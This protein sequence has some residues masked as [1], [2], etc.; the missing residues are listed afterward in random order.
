M[1]GNKNNKEIIKNQKLRNNEYY[2][3]QEEFDRLYKQSSEG[4][5]F[6]N[7]YEIIIKEENILLAYR[8]IKNNK[9]SKTKGCDGKN[10]EY[11]NNFNSEELVRKIQKKLTNYTPKGIKRVNIPKPN[12]KTRPLGIPCIED[13]II[14][15]AIK[16]VMEPICESKFH[17]HSYG[18]RPNRSTENAIARCTYLIN[19]SQMKYVVDIDIKSFFDN[20]NHSKLKKQIWNIGIRDKRLI[21][22][23]GKMLKAPIIDKDNKYTP[24]KGTPQGGILSPLLSNIV[25]NELDWW[26]SNQW[27]TFNTRHNYAR[28]R[29]CEG[30]GI[31]Y[32]NKYTSL[33]RTTKLKEIWLVRYADD[34]KIFCKDY[35]TA[36]KIYNATKLWLK[37]RL[38]LEISAEKSK[39]TNL[40]K[41]YTEF[42]GFKFKIIPKKKKYACKSRMSNKAKEKVIRQI[43]EQ[44][45][46]I[47]RKT[48]TA[49]ADRL[50]KIIIGC[51]NYYRIATLVS[52]DFKHID[53]LLRKSFETRLKRYMS[54][55]DR[56]SELYKKR[57]GR[58]NVKTK[59][60]CG[61]TIFPIFACSM[62]IP[63]NFN[64]NIC[65]YTEQGRALIHKNLTGKTELIGEI[66]KVKNGINTEGLDNSISKLVG[67]NYKCYVTN[68]SLNSN[69]MIIFNVKTKKTLKTSKSNSYKNIVWIKKEIHELIIKI[70]NN[71]SNL[72]DISKLT[73]KE[74]SKLSKLVK[75]PEK[76]YR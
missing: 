22:I 10:I 67:Q 4:K 61:I 23:I 14:Q 28:D 2:S 57:Y 63:R 48:N 41:N 31:D 59:T 37:E 26:I 56:K 34:F 13:R 54:N 24:K 16:Q 7:L 65:N 8:N 51:H 27:E 49:E 73:K 19:R 39:I 74:I 43:K 69:N 33:R 72:K 40:K 71:E 21:S 53:F 62:K 60:V 11:L 30:K 42:L 18:F 58:Y 75:L 55:T 46:T 12:G 36:Q 1:T 25:L 50:N 29:S 44:I 70:I 38:N 3:M 45:K 47:Q 5:V 35:I 64:N 68:Q 6:K 17:K 32:S 52:H 76:V 20:V 66:V 15:Q 9:G